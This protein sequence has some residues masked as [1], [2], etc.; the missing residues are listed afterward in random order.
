VFVYA[1]GIKVNEIIGFPTQN[2]FAIVLTG[3]AVLYLPALLGFGF[4]LLPFGGPVGAMFKFFGWMLGLFAFL[5][6]LGAL[7]LS[8]FGTRNVAVDP[9][10]SVPANPE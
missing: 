7:F 2:P 8:R 6:G 9:P 4:S 1:L 10:A 3:M 5:A